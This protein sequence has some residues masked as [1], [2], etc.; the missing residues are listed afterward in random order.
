MKQQTPNKQQTPSFSWLRNQNQPGNVAG[1]KERSMDP[2]VGSIRGPA[3]RLCQ[4]LGSSSEQ[5]AKQ[6]II[7][8]FFFLFTFFF[9]IF[10]PP[11]RES[12]IERGKKKKK[13]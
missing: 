7:L 2:R 13:V 5:D 1:G 4:A 3:A 9:A 6:L 10:F 12:R 8:V 11:E